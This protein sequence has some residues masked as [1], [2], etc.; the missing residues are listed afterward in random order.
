MCQFTRVTSGQSE[1]LRVFIFANTSVTN[2]EPDTSLYW[3]TLFLIQ[4]KQYVVE[5]RKIWISLCHYSENVYVSCKG[6]M[7][8][9]GVLS[10]VSSST[11]RVQMSWFKR[12]WTVQHTVPYVI[13]YFIAF[14]VLRIEWMAWRCLLNVACTGTG[15]S[16]SI[17][18]YCYEKNVLS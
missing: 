9:T 7:L 8:C 18:L 15:F 11:T 1:H 4:S 13:R 10:N 6:L 17:Y 3:L 5:K 16:D 14:I 2:R 12:T